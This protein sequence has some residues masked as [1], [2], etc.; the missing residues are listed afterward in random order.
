MARV[1]GINFETVPEL[2]VSWAYPLLGG[3][4]ILIGFGLLRYF[5]KL[6]WL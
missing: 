1:Y 5:R 4:M 3:I 2:K 6:G